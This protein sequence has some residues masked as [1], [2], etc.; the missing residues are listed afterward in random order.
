MYALPPSPH[1]RG[2]D[3]A[4]VVRACVYACGLARALSYGARTPRTGST[5]HGAPS[6]YSITK[7]SLLYAPS[8]PAEENADGVRCEFRRATF[9]RFIDFAAR[10]IVAHFPVP[11]LPLNSG[12]N[13]ALTVPSRHITRL[14]DANKCQG[15]RGRKR[16]S[17]RVYRHVL[18][19]NITG[20]AAIN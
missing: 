13:S 15:A 3:R 8:I 9:A 7:L 2:S 19:F 10:I 11:H 17:R 1:L 16:R 14:F 12:Y 6:I 20:I 18:M 5:Q 4:S